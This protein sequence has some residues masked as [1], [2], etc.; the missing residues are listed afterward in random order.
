MKV[1]KQVILKDRFCR[2]S[3]TSKSVV[4]GLDSPAR[5]NRKTHHELKLIVTPRKYFT[6]FT[7]R[8]G[9]LYNEDKECV[10]YG[11]TIFNKSEVITG[12][13]SFSVILETYSVTLEELNE[14]KALARKQIDEMEDLMGI[15]KPTGIELKKD[16]DSLF[17][18]LLYKGSR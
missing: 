3:A 8:L 14:R 4:L 13:F 7:C 9:K 18:K 16:L 11:I 15:N 6:A 17:R 1:K 2:F 5:L 10:A 12:E